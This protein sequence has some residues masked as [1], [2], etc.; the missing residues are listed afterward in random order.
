MLF[1]LGTE[2]R[3][4]RLQYVGFGTPEDFYLAHDIGGAP[5]YEHVLNVKIEGGNVPHSG[6]TISF[7]EFNDDQAL[8]PSSARVLGDY[9][10]YAAQTVEMSVV[11]EILHETMSVL[12]PFQ[13]GQKNSQTVTIDGDDLSCSRYN[14]EDYFY[15]LL[16]GTYAITGTIFKH[17][18]SQFLFS[19]DCNQVDRLKGSIHQVPVNIRMSPYTATRCEKGGSWSCR[20]YGCY[21][22]QVE[23]VDLIFSNRLKLSSE[24]HT[25]Q[26]QAKRLHSGHCAS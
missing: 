15:A 22:Y 8:R 26:D 9:D 13:A 23:Y 21:Q 2:G 19:G 11:K 1:I 7:Q 24:V 12:A 17:Q 5:N 20:Q 25:S 18:F 6:A 14:G 16:N 10:G 4:Q 3:P